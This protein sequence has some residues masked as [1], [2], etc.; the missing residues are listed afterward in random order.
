MKPII[1]SPKRTEQVYV[2]IRD[3]ICD[4]SLAPSTHLVQED[5]AARLGVSRQPV[6]Q[7]MILL[8]NDGLVVESDRR[9]LYVAPLD[10]EATINRY[11]IRIA[12]DQL[13]A[14]LVAER[15]ADS[16]NFAARLRREGGKILD[17]GVRALNEERFYEAVT[18]DLKFHW[19]VY[20]MSGNPLIGITAEPHWH[21]LRRVMNAVLREARRGPVVWHEHLQILDLLVAGD[22]E[23]SLRMAERHARG[24]QDA[25]IAVLPGPHRATRQA[26]PATEP[27]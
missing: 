12:L 23:G 15:A 11:Q 13:A 19:L 2:A 16:R 26:E 8:K 25:F 17:A 4:G 18:H 3:S 1:S 6:Q 10:A 22:I 27:A 21:Y 20:E 9:G 14:R 5:L 24:A 7:A